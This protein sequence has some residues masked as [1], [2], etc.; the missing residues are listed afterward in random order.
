MSEEFTIFGDFE[1]T[2]STYF[3]VTHSSCDFLNNAEC[4]SREEVQEWLK[5]KYVFVVYTQVR[6]DELTG[7]A[8]KESLLLRQ[9]VNRWV[10]MHTRLGLASTW[11]GA[12]RFYEVE[13]ITDQALV[14]RL[15]SNEFVELNDNMMAL[16]FEVLETV[17]HIEYVPRA[18]PEVYHA[19]GSIGGAIVLLCLLGKVTVGVLAKI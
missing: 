18:G 10:M 3:A 17:T 16:T 19:I 7:E 14:E 2:N 4:K 5:H 6:R 11:D 9:P 1:T 13:R 8:I 12:E 15:P